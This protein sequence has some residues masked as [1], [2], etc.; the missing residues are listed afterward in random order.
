M[1]GNVA[2]NAAHAEW[3]ASG[4]S[5]MAASLRGSSILVIAARVRELVASGVEVCN[6]T[7]GDF[8]PK[9]YPVPTELRVGTK[10]A[11]DAGHTNYPPAN[12]IPALRTAVAQMYGRRLG[13]NVDPANVSVA[14]GARPLLFAAYNALVGEGDKVVY[15]SPSWNNNH[16]TQ[17]VGANAV[18]LPVGPEDNFFP[19]M[20][21]FA[22]HL[23]D[24]RLFFLNS[25][26][27]PSGTMIRRDV[28]E[29][30]C[31]SIVGENE[32]RRA[33]GE[34]PLFLLYDQIYW[35]LR[36]GDVE[37]FD[38][39]GVDPRMADYA[40]Y[41]DGI[42]KAFAATGMRVGWGVSPAPL[43]AAMNRLLGHVGAWAPHPEQH[44]TAALLDDDDAVDRYLAWI[45]RE[46]RDRLQI[47][48]D[49]VSSM[50]DAG[51]PVQALAPEGAIYLSVQID[52]R[53]WKAGDK[54]LQTTAEIG[55]YLLDEAGV[56]VVPFDA[57]GATHAQAWFRLSV[58]AVEREALARAL[59]RVQ[60]AL[61]RLQ[62]P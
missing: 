5:P 28:L 62:R 20:E 17:I 33:A 34:K 35:M 44:A 47:I 19:K 24:A 56:A 32:R 40:I 41:V 10:R 13:I 43:A 50:A 57:F 26:L 21:A 59:D 39:I 31:A 12:G 37:H 14:S 4:L 58:G 60:A 1:S 38:P 7:I 15:A 22:P 51:L 16:Y 46:A 48:F 29:E 18:K 6:L 8:N 61:G 27:N 42:S 3:L 55:N 9:A 49:K 11:L 54:V 45:Q 53:G 25:P 23:Q 2:P 36:L 30:L 52:V